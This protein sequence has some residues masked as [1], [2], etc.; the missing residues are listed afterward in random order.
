MV[1]SKLPYINKRIVSQKYYDN[2]VYYLEH[3]SDIVSS[4]FKNALNYNAAKFLFDYFDKLFIIKCPMKVAVIN[5]SNNSLPKYESK[6]AAGMDVRADFSRVTPQNPIKL[7]G[8]GEF[9]FEKKMLRLDP[10]SRALIPTG[11][12]VALP[13]GVE[14][15]VRPRSGMALKK[16]LTVI[17]TPGTVD[18]DYR[19]EVGVPIVNLSSEEVWI[20]TGERIC[21]F[22][23][24][25]VEH[26]EWELVDTLDETERGEGGFGHSGV[27]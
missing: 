20:E 1:N 24:N 19:G 13:E 11:I 6:G 4:H 21:Q 2:L 25:V 7:Y 9:D 14:M 22:V 18:E 23:F 5:L 3:S 17:N 8:S 12:K 26:A 27:K 10:M 15:Q 16:G